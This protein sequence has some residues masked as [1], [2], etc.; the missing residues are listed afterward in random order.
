MVPQ[1]VTN[2]SMLMLDL[3]KTPTVRGM[4]ITQHGMPL[5]GL[6]ALSLGITS[7]SKMEKKMPSQTLKAVTFI[8]GPHHGAETTRETLYQ[9][10]W[11]R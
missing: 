2:I 7:Q 10:Q 9:R 3:A 6:A 8:V 1:R 11:S 4:A 5:V